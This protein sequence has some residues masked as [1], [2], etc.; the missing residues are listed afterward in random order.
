MHF[1]YNSTCIEYIDQ[2]DGQHKQSARR[3]SYLAQDANLIDVTC[4][5]GQQLVNIYRVGRLALSYI[6]LL[7]NDGA[8][9][10]QFISAAGRGIRSVPLTTSEMST[11]SK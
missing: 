4:R 10:M 1:I 7:D 2:L 9:L 3:V 8:C 5:V 6:C 11:S